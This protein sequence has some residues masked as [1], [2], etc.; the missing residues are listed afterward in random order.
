[1]TALSPAAVAALW[2][3]PAWKLLVPANDEEDGLKIWDWEGSRI[4]LSPLP[5]CE[6]WFDLTEQNPIS[7]MGISSSFIL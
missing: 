5:S 1:M 6:Q 4:L 7:K 3:P 2:K